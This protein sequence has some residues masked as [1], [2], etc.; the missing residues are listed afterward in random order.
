MKIRKYIFLAAAALISASWLT[1]CLSDEDDSFDYK[2]WKNQ[3]ETFYIRMMD[4]VAPD[5]NKVFE[6]IT[7]VWAPGVNVLAQWH[8]DT[9]LTGGSL[10]PMDNSTV[11]VVYDCSYID[12]VLLD[13]S[14]RNNADS[15]YSCKPNEN[16]VGFWAMLTRMHVGDSVTCI[17]PS[18]AAYGASNS[19]IKPYS[20]LI[21][22]MKLKAIKAYEVSGK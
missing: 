1:S 2:A 18:D 17:I 8:N 12:G 16:I 21:Y 6:K 5:G 14:A 4:S 10:V 7:P 3:N 22:H 13:S 11:D 19:R 15:I 9:T 20:A